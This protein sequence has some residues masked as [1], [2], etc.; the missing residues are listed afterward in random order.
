[1]ADG[2]YDP[3]DLVFGDILTEERAA[4]IETQ[5]KLA[6]GREFPLGGHFNIGTISGDWEDVPGHIIVQVDERA[7]VKIHAM[8]RLSGASPGGSPTAVGLFRLWD[9]TAGAAV[10]NTETEFSDIVATLVISATEVV[11]DQ[12]S[13]YKL[14]VRTS[15]PAEDVI[16]YGA[17]LVTQ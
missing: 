10:A 15:D 12:F 7:A 8:C 3:L 14:Q 6:K 9:I 17:T 2:K 4:W 13:Q 1:M 16:V 5:Y 11:L